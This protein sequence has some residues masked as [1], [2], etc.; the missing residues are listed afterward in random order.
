MQISEGTLR[1]YGFIVYRKLW[2]IFGFDSFFDQLKRKHTKLQFDLGS[3]VFLMVVQHLL[4]PMSK[5]STY[6][7]RSLEHRELCF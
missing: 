5:L 3:V 6:E 7:R 4:S 1:N 2:Q